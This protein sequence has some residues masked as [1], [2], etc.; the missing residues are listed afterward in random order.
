M[1][2]R[3]VHFLGTLSVCEHHTGM[4][5]RPVIIA[6]QVEGTAGRVISI[7]YT[8]IRGDVSAR[9]APGVKKILQTRLPRA[10]AYFGGSTS[11][12]IACS[13][14]GAEVQ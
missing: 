2:T 1:A 8:E 13:R 12:V 3:L 11:C 5:E 9:L 6:P 4:S 14:R 7:S 10:E